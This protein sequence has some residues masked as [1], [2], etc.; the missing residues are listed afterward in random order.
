MTRRSLVLTACLLALAT[1]SSAQTRSPLNGKWD[2]ELTPQG[3]PQSRKVVFELAV[4]EKGRV[5]G[6]LTGMPQPGDVKAGSFDAKSGAL[7][8]EVG[9]AGEP[10][11]LLTLEGTVVKD[12]ASGKVRAADG[13]GDFT[14]TKQK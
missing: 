6:T 4:D 8:L 11:V 5:T 1:L 10:A 2:G 7:K 13:G 9:I 3:A 12:T 14:L